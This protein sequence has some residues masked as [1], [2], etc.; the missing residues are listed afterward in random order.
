MMVSWCEGV[1]SVAE[2]SITGMGMVE[3]C[4]GEDKMV[5]RCQGMERSGEMEWRYWQIVG[6]TGGLREQGERWGDGM[7]TMAGFGRET[8][9]CCDVGYMGG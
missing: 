4:W 7:G 2:D 1:E 5:S 8:M 9:S 3:G 6:E